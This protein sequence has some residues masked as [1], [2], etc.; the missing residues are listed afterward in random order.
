M[1]NTPRPRMRSTVRS[2]SSRISSV[3]GRLLRSHGARDFRDA[4]A[5]VDERRRDGPTATEMLAI[6]SKYA[7]QPVDQLQLAVS[8][9]DGEARLDEQSVRHQ[10]AWSKSQNMVRADIASD[11][12]IDRRYVVT[13]PQ[14]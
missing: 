8:Y 1:G 4:F 5:D 6:L 2:R 12:I 9:I 10:I 3:I 11:G 14:Q 13:L 7:G